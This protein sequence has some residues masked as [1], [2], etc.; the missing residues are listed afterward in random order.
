MVSHI[1]WSQRA[2]YSL[3]QMERYY[4]RI[5]LP[6]RYRHSSVPK[7]DEAALDHLR[8]LL[9]HQVAAVPFENLSLHYSAHRSISTDPFEIFE[10]VVG[11]KAERGGY[12]MENSCLFGTV[13]RSLGYQVYPVGGRVNEAAQ[14]M[15]ASQN[16]KGPKF[17]GWNHM[18]N[19]VT[20]GRQRYLVDV[21]FGSNG[22]HQ[23]VPLVE[24][25]EFHNVGNQ[26]GRLVHGPIAQH[27]RA[28]QS[29]WQYEFANGEPTRWISGYCFTEEEFLPEDFTIM[30]YFMSTHRESWFTFHLVC[31]RMILDEAGERV[32]GDLTLFN[33]KLKRRVGTT[34]ELVASFVS[35]EERVAALETYFHIPLTAADRESIRHTIAEIL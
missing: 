32:I 3:E 33:D 20:I 24:G 30:N 21:G 4:D 11:S 2:S 26:R 15:S 23:P 22:P 27:T 6:L 17:D 25:H 12:C 7:T 28:G 29:M 35:E 1:D 19:I 31:V 10:K 18:V 8:V 9:H 34:S 13:L 14:P 16:W 5:H